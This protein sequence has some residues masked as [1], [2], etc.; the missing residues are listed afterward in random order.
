VIL[1]GPVNKCEIF[2]DTGKQHLRGVA[3][4]LLKRHLVG[5]SRLLFFLFFLPVSHV[6]GEQ[7]PHYAIKAIVDVQNKIISAVEEVTFT[8]NSGQAL[9]EIYFHIYPN[10][11]Y[12]AKEKNFMLRYAGYFKI[13]PFPEGFQSGSVNVE[14]IAQDGTEVFSAIEGDDQTIL[15]VSLLSP[16]A[17]GQSVRL[18][19]NFSVKIPHAYGRFGWHENIMALSRWYPILSVL[20][21]NGWN[22]Y[23]F[24][25]FHR[26]FFS[27]AAYYSVELTVPEDQVVIHSGHLRE[28]KTDA[29]GKILNIE[30]S[31]PI[32]E[33]TLALSPDYKV[34]TKN[35]GDVKISSFY[36]P[37]DQSHAQMALESASDLM[38]YYT[39]LFGVYPYEEFN[40]APVYLGWGGEQ[41]SNMTFIDTRVYKLPKFLKRY[42]DFLVAHETGHQWLYNIVGID[43][44]A[45]IWLEEGVHSYFLLGYLE[46]K[47]GPDAKVVELPKGLEWLLPNFSFRRARDLRYQFIARNNLD[48][49]V[50]D[51]LSSFSEP[52]SIFSLT[53]GKGAGITAM[54]HDTIGDEA[55]KKVFTRIFDEYRFKNLSV[56][57]FIKLCERESGKALDGFFNQW[58]YTTKKCDISV[59]DV[60]GNKILLENRREIVMPV[61]VD[62]QFADGRKERILWDGQKAT[63][64]IEV[65]FAGR[66]KKV[67]VDPEG[68]LLDIDRTN[69]SWPRTVTVRPVPL[70]LGLYDIPIF[71]R[72]DVYNVVAGPEIANSGIG[73][74]ASFQKPYDQI[75]YAAGDYEIGE[76]LFKTRTGYEL[77]NV[78]NALTTFGF[79]LFNVDDLDGGEEDLAGGKV[80]LRKELWPA[81]YNLTSINDH[82][83]F[84]LLRNRSLNPSSLTGSEDSRNVSYLRKDEAIVGTN[85]HFDRS[86]PGIDPSQGYQMDTFFESSGH[87]LEATQYFNRGAVDFSMYRGITPKTKLAWRL[88]YGGGFPSD[89]NLFE[90]GGV[91]GL[92]GYDRKTLR[93]AN[94]ALSSLEYRFPIIEKLDLHFFDNILGV[95]SISGVVF[96]DA[97]QSWRGD[98]E[99]SQLKKDAGLGLRFTVN[100]G[101]FLEKVLVRADV[102]QAIREPKEDTRF[103]FGVGHAF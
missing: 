74:K 42:L 58:L 78:F 29:G 52:S 4:D 77:K 6:F 8:N 46:D 88:K 99:D 54:L 92:R 96:A 1:K 100:V 60:H 17:G 85:F 35:F 57:D 95:E 13:N 33:F 27:E 40:I 47:Y 84:Y 103:W 89:K 79:E 62:V 51:K 37:G 65:K 49:P 5:V 72:D 3:R 28:T 101:S 24:Y 73:L 32:R 22:N 90:L 9:N 18:T 82:V 86:S 50:V 19:I 55:F 59:K 14:S 87:F 10:R 83:T 67:S 56:E 68:K 48:H 63:D 38:K 23:P 15:K 102:A 61:E 41:M 76:D 66:I 94:M 11:Q 64:Q 44:Y 25:P 71:L 75:W 91:N 97:G 36:L 7:Y 45:Q 43:E 16:L 81:P 39:D 12:T 93:G 98:F 70:Y 34:V 30:T 26:P 2:K 80:Y 20:N 21:Q 53:Y 69:N 31:S